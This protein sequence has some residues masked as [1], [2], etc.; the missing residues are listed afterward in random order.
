MRTSY[1]RGQG[2]ALTLVALS[3][4]PLVGC[5]SAP[6][7][8][9]YAPREDLLTTPEDWEVGE[10]CL[11]RLC[12]ERAKFSRAEGF[13]EWPDTERKI[14]GKDDLYWWNLWRGYSSLSSGAE[15][16]RD[17][18]RVERV[19]VNAKS[20]YWD[21]FLTP[22]VGPIFNALGSDYIS[23]VIGGL[24]LAFTGA[25]D[26]LYY[27]VPHVLPIPLG[28]L[29]RTRHVG[30]LAFADITDVRVM[31]YKSIGSSVPASYEVWADVVDH[32]PV[33]FEAASLAEA[34]HLVDVLQAFRSRALAAAPPGK[35]R[36]RSRWVSPHERAKGLAARTKAQA[37]AKPESKPGSSPQGTGSEGVRPGSTATWTIQNRGSEPVKLLVSV[38]GSLQSHDVPPGKTLRLCVSPGSY[39]YTLRCGGERTRGSVILR[40]G[41]TT[42]TR[43]PKAP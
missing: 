40:A 20:D 13:L 9:P 36:W 25:W 37:K 34:Q 4:A 14:L 1:R 17:G 19:V 23:G 26:T 3:L 2:L 15:V 38:E 22:K 39:R 6:T 12:L 32:A 8:V 24:V 18:V 29:E 21:G 33:T 11:E 43:Y 10:R 5:T 31:G 16:D 27:V 28:D 35:V 41:V 7:R 42:R 30:R